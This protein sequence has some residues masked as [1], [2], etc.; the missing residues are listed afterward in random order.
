MTPTGRSYKIR[1]FQNG[2]S[3]D[4]SKIF[5]NYAIT[6]PTDIAKQLPPDT[7]YICSMDEQGLHF[8]PVSLIEDQPKELPAWAKKQQEEK[9]GSEPPKP[10]PKRSRPGKKKDEPV[11]V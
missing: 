7:K 1:Q 2:R 3:Q 10:K 9:N 11:E 4:G 8:T 6:V 5:L